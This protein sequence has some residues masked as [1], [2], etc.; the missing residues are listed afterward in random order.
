MNKKKKEKYRLRKEIC[1]RPNFPSHSNF[2]KQ[3]YYSF[4]LKVKL[5]FKVTYFWLYKLLFFGTFGYL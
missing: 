3:E 1:G 4:G 5:R 2:R